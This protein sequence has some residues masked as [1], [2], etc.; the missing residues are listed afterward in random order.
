LGGLHWVTDIR[1]SM[2]PGSY[3]TTIQ[4][5]FVSRGDKVVTDADTGTN[6][7]A[8]PSTTVVNPTENPTGTVQGGPSE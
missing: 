1:S 8:D 2:T 5:R 4:A 7:N 3:K 6:A